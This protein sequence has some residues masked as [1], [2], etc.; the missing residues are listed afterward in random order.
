MWTL[1]SRKDK[2]W[3]SVI[4]NIIFFSRMVVRANVNKPIQKY[5][6]VCLGSGTP[7]G[8]KLCRTFLMGQTFTSVRVFYVW[9]VWVWGAE[10]EP[11]KSIPKSSQSLEHPH[12]GHWFGEN[13][14]A[15]VPNQ[16]TMPVETAQ[17]LSLELLQKSLRQNV[18]RV[19]FWRGR[20]RW[21]SLEAA[22]CFQIAS[23]VCLVWF[24][25]HKDLW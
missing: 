14:L 4:T 16:R 5:C 24:C 1:S 19:G 7:L 3:S 21:A 2:G 13:T 20:A 17:H 18:L 22:F 23:S 15:G 9:F 10:T 12:C 8:D 25:W 11:T 6:V